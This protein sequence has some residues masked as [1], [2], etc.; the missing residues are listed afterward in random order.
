LT[1]FGGSQYVNSTATGRYEDYVVDELVPFVDA[2]FRTLA[3][4]D[5]RGVVG[6]SSGGYGAL[7]LGMRHPDVFG[8]VA[9]HAGDLYFELCYKCDIPRAVAGLA[10]FGGSVERFLEA[11]PAV[12]PKGHDHIA[13]LNLI[14][15]SA[16]YS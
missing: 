13:A 11:F 6:K 1:R 15:M 12:E 5:H 2:H 14:A 10:P 4:R 8:A 9:S 16:A 7:V 3:S